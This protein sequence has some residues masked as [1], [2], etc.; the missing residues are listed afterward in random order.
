MPRW[1]NGRELLRAPQPSPAQVLQPALRAPHVREVV[2]LVF[3]V[4]QEHVRTDS[5]VL[6]AIAGKAVRQGGR[7]PQAPLSRRKQVRSQVRRIERPGGP[8]VT[9][10]L[11]AE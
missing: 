3:G 2:R 1:C 6:D 11:D 10:E 8:A 7:I 4:R 9:D 5:D